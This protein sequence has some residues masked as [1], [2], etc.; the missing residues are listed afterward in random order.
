MISFTSVIDTVGKFLAN[1]RNHMKNQAKL[2]A[3]IAHSTH[4]GV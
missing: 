2:P 3:R 1:S 4:D